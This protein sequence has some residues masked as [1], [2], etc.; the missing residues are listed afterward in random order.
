MQSDPWQELYWWNETLNTT[1]E[2]IWAIILVVC[3]PLPPNLIP[4][5]NHSP[6]GVLC[7]C[8]HWVVQN[9]N[10]H[11]FLIYDSSVYT[12]CTCTIIC[13]AGVFEDGSEQT[14]HE[15]RSSVQDSR[16]CMGWSV[17]L[18]YMAGVQTGVHVFAICVITGIIIK[19][20]NTLFFHVWAPNIYGTN[21][22][23]YLMVLF[24][25]EFVQL[26]NIFLID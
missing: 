8:I 16:T 20:R 9:A 7:L 19:M 17:K 13:L 4:T 23:I 12:I 21:S 1:P 2:T 15:K 26:S 3:R 11:P 6:G 25:T 24:F 22:T 10:Q 18:V 5:E 14:C